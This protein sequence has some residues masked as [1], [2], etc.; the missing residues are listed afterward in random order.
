MFT[1]GHFDAKGSSVMLERSW[2]RTASAP[3][4][5]QFLQSYFSSWSSWSPS[6]PWSWSGH[7]QCRTLYLNSAPFGKLKLLGK[8]CL[9]DC[10]STKSSVPTNLWTSPCSRLA[11]GAGFEPG[12]NGH[13][14][15]R[16]S[17]GD[18]HSDEGG[19]GETES[20]HL[21]WALV[22]AIWILGSGGLCSHC[23]EWE[24]LS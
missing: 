8:A 24:W 12:P 23:T 22:I 16:I 17:D 21:A 1:R 15:V 5:T 20:W 13:C 7:T 9:D 10:Q 19:R 6:W 3:G 18:G 2:M 14:M 11:C 4:S